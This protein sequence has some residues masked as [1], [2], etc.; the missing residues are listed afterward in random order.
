MNKRILIISYNFAPRHTVGAIRPTKLAQYLSEAGEK[1]DV[2][3]VKPFGELDH[4]MDGVFEHIDRLYEIDCPIIKE[5]APAPAA[6]KPQAKPE[7]RSAPAPAPRMKGLVKKLKR[8]I[9][10]YR[11]V[12]GSRRFAAEFKKL[13]KSDLDNFR[14]YDA[15]ISSYGPVAS[16]LCGLE[17]KALCPGV[18]WIADFRDPMVVNATTRLTRRS[19]LKIQ[20]RVC[21]KADRLVAVSEG[22][23]DKIFEGEAKNKSCVIYNGFDRRDIDLP[24]VSPDKSFNFTYVGALYDGK[25]DISPLFAVLSRLEAEGIIEK[26]KVRFNYAGSAF[27]VL[28]GQAKKYGLADCLYDLGRLDRDQCL[29]LQAASRHLVLATWN[30]EKEGGV[31]PG[32]FLEYI[33]AGRPIISLVSGNVPSSEVTRVIE[34]G[35]LGVTYEDAT[36]EDDLNKLKNYVLHDYLL[37]LGGEPPEFDPDESVVSSFDFRE[38]AKRFEELIAE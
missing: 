28:R 20:R 26:E 14:S 18:K 19:R 31:F 29:K 9:Y 35:R 21:K 15:V 17:M 16:H 32:K 11:R 34:R 10:E 33:M 36:A 23:S 30:E 12:S 37:W 24:S 4:S 7:V 6:T 1:V 13:V 8:E 22:Y 5:K 3:T 27:E 2:V 25:R 38:T